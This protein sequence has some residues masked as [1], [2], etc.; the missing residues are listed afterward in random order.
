MF[1]CVPPDFLLG[2]MHLKKQPPLLASYR[3]APSMSS[4]I[5][6]GVLWNLLVGLQIL[7]ACV[8]DLSTR[9]GCQHFFQ[10]LITSPSFWCLSAVL[11]VLCCYSR[12]PPHCPFFSLALRQPEYIS[13]PSQAKHKPVTCAAIQKAGTPDARSTLL[14]PSQGWSF[15]LGT[16]SWLCRA[17]PASDG[18]AGSLVPN[19]AS[20]ISTPSRGAWPVTQAALK[21]LELWMNLPLSSF[22][23]VPM[24]GK[25]SQG[26][27]CASLGEA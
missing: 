15:E 19:R 3:G 21:K 7:W 8:C 23:L 9:E 4:C 1:L 2:F 26:L 10:E 18:M 11:R 13:T 24:M 27:S 16:V 12:K 20:S 6:A 25:L 14:P 22:P 5:D 17:T